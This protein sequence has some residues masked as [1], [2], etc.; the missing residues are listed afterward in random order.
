VTADQHNQVVDE[1]WAASVSTGTND[2]RLRA[3]G[4]VIDMYSG[5]AW[6]ATIRRAVYVVCLTA[7]VV[8][9]L[10]RLR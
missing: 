2:E 9:L 6:R 3:A 10:W 4:Q 1:A 5:R 8:T 7:I